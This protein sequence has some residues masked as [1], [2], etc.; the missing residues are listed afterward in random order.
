MKQKY[1]RLD[2]IKKVDA[3][4]KMLLGERSNGKSYAVKEESLQDAWADDN[5]KFIYLR[6]WDLEC[7][8][9][10]TEQYFLDAPIS[11][12]TKGEADTIVVY[13]GKIFFAKYDAETQKPKKIKICGYTRAL[14]MEG[15]YV[16][17]SYPDVDKIFFEEFISRDYYLPGEV[18]K[19]MQFVSTVARRR[20]ILVYLIGNTISRVCPYFSDWQLV[21]IPRQ[22]QGT[23]DIYEFKTEEFNE[24]GTPVVVKIA[25]EMCENS[26]HNSKM[27]F[28]VNSKMI[29]SG[30]WQCEEKP[31]LPGRKMIDYFKLYEVFFSMDNFKFKGELLMSKDTSSLLWYVTPKTS[32]FKFKNNDRIISDHAILKNNM[33]SIGLVPFNNN[34]SYV[35]SLLK[36]GWIYY[37]DNLTGSEFEMC[38]KKLLQS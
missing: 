34:E 30:S 7:K 32:D 21:N 37:S 35:F 8:P 4:Y 19:L 23:I 16:S 17:G 18:N 15:H 13:M 10:L 38:L 36:Q 31:H 3:Q 28:G 22:K 33:T 14:S 29:T 5:K 24:D 12:I 26:G 9:S 2:K 20:Q 25:V 11:A 1:Y 6:R 27:F